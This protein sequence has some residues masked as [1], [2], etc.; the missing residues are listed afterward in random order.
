MLSVLF[1]NFMSKTDRKKYE[2]DKSVG[3]TIWQLNYF[4]FTNGLITRDTQRTASIL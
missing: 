1:T 2:Y 4:V 3:F